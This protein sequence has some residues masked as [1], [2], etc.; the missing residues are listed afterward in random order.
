MLLVR[1]KVWLSL[2]WLSTRLMPD[3]LRGFE[4]RLAA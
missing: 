3:W 2:G 1:R 4:R